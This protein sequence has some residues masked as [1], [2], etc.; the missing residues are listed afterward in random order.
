[1]D[2]HFDTHD[3][4]YCYTH[5]PIQSYAGAYVPKHFNQYTNT[6]NAHS[7]CQIYKH[8]C[9]HGHADLVADIY[10]LAHGDENKFSYL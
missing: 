5:T 4:P 10:N 1:L 8:Q 3:H 6:S 2:T 9:S 7:D